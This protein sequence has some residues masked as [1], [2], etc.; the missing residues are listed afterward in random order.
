[1][2]AVTEIIALF[3]RC[4]RCGQP[5]ERDGTGAQVDDQRPNRAAHSLCVDLG[6]HRSAA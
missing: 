4:V 3:P 2:T 1:M 5:L 6:F